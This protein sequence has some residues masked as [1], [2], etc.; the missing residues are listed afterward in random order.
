MS[1]TARE[2]CLHAMLQPEDNDIRRVSGFLFITDKEQQK[3]EIIDY[4]RYYNDTN[5]CEL[6]L[7]INKLE[8]RAD[9]FQ[10]LLAAY[11]KKVRAHKVKLE[12]KQLYSMDTKAFF[13]SYGFA[14]RDCVN[15]RLLNP[16]NNAYNDDQKDAMQFTHNGFMREG[17]I[18]PGAVEFFD[19]GKGSIYRAMRPQ[20]KMHHNGNYKTRKKY[21]NECYRKAAK[22][23]EKYKTTRDDVV[24]NDGK[25]VVVHDFRDE[26]I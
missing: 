4:L 21:L 25:D 7:Y 19:M 10:A 1:K 17:V 14:C 22:I 13:F 11:I 9:M 6:D 23:I 3:T 16:I 2:I 18:E 12:F 20:I 15:K 24:F 5:H 26:L 8:N